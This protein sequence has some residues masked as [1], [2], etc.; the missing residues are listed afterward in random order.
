MKSEEIIKSL[1]RHFSDKRQW[2]TFKELR[3]GTGYRITHT[4]KGHEPNNPEQRIDFWAMN[5]YQSKKF[6]KIAFE[7][8]VSRSDFL[9]EINN[10]EKRQRALLLSNRFYFAAPKGLIGLEE[11]PV[12]CG[13]VEFG[14]GEVIRYWTK[15]APW[16]EAQEPSWSFLASLARR[17]AKLE[18]EA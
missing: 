18:V 11:I 7:I 16:R 5:C 9:N 17:I 1:E 3:V 10:P 14:E 4:Y 2:A 6:E 13:L 8:K 15:H 12:E